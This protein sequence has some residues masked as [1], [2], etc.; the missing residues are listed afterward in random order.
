MEPQL[1]F[2]ISYCLFYHCGKYLEFYL[3]LIDL[4]KEGLSWEQI[5]H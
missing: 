3:F 5:T 4:I 2:H 1:I